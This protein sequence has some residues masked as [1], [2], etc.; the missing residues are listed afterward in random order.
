MRQRIASSLR[1]FRSDRRFVEQTKLGAELVGYVFIVAA[2]FTVAVGLG[3]LTAGL[4]LVW[5][6]NAGRS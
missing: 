5:L 1:R 6:G 2:A 4:A 3:L